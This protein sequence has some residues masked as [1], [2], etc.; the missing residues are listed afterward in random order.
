MAILLAICAAVP[1]GITSA[2]KQDTGLDYCSRV[3]CVIG[4]AL[5]TFWFGILIVYALAAFLPV[6]T[7]PGLCHAVGRSAAEPAA[8]H[9]PGPDAG[10]R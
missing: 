2:V 7:P 9:L 8:T 3:F 10:L 6:V 5:P 4:V 1:L